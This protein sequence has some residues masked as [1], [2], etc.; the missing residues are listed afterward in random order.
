MRL[1]ALLAVAALATAALA[2]EYQPTGIVQTR[3]AP[4]ERTKFAKL[5]VLGISDDRETRHRFEDKLVTHLRSRGVEAIT[6]YSIVDDLTK[7]ADREQVLAVLAREKV[8]GALTARAVGMRESGEDAWAEG[9][10]AWMDSPATIRDLV[11]QSIPVPK[12]KAKRYGVEITLW[13][14]RNGTRPWSAR[15]SLYER[16]K[17]RE[18]ASGLMQDTIA[19]LRELKFI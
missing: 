11:Q 1:R 7:P 14:L 18:A 10:S 3:V 13:E 19:R 2:A 8:E 6:S 5:L 9:W 15:T 4:G 17:L 12:E 16:K